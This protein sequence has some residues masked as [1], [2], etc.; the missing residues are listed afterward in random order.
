MTTVPQ[1]RPPQLD[2]RSDLPTAIQHTN[3]RMREVAQTV[4]AIQSNALTTGQTLLNVSA[5]EF[6]ASASRSASFNYR[7]IQ[8]ALTTASSINA[9]VILPPGTLDY[10]VTLDVPVAVSVYGSGLDVST[11]RYTGTTGDG[12]SM[13]GTGGLKHTLHGF[14][15][16][17]L[18]TSTGS[19]INAQDFRDSVISQVRLRLFAVGLALGG[20][21]SYS[22]LFYGLVCDDNTQD[23]VN[24]SLDCNNNT[25]LNCKMNGNAR[26]GAY[27][28]GT[29]AV[30]FPGCDFEGN[31][32]GAIVTASAG[33]ATASVSFPAS[34]YF[35][36]NTVRDLVITSNDA[37]VTKPKGTSVSDGYFQPLTVNTTSVIRVEYA[38]GVDL[39]NLVVDN[40]GGFT[41]L[42][43]IELAA[44]G[45]SSGVR[46]NGLIDHS[47]SQTT[48]DPTHTGVI[49]WVEASARAT[50]APVTG[51]WVVGDR[52]IN[53][54]PTVGQP[55]AWVCTVAGTPG[56]WISE[57]N[58]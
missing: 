10:T 56:T 25:F 45:S 3:Q 34:C 29:R 48:V 28:H 16:T 27:L 22:N 1:F 41:Y 20:V 26:A 23:G 18:T 44:G 30:S 33:Y 57:G 5:P 35:E 42:N 4:A 52:V 46:V 49:K 24:L 31:A 38:E 14:T 55:K 21:T 50:A 15:V 8:D 17:A 39:Q 19:A 37:G 54:V 6:G 9:A 32:Y 11:L 2:T 13:S 36:G 58:L 51:T 40:Q 47:A 43:S 12:I 53:S 7:A